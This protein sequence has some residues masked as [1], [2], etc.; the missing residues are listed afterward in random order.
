MQNVLIHELSA[1]P[2]A[3]FYPNGAIRYTAKCNLL[4]KNEIKTY[5]LPSLTGNLDLGA[6][7]TDFMAILQYI[8]YKSKLGR[9]SNVVD[10]IY[11]KLLTSS[12]AFV[13]VNCWL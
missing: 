6:T 1:V 4:N 8:Y 13:N 5:S 12:Q 2:L 3:L 7:I 10:E 11:T 9:S